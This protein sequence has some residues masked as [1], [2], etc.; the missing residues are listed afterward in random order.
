M[1]TITV[2]ARGLA[3]PEPV[4]LSKKAL[5]EIEHGEVIVYVDSD[6]AKENVAR[7]A[8]HEGCAVALKG[9]GK[10]G[11]ELRL[12]IN[13][14]A[15]A[16]KTHEHGEIK[17]REAKNKAH[18]EGIVY[19]FDADFIGTNRELGKVLVNGFLNAITSLQ[20]R[21]STIVFISNGVKLTTK[22]SYVLEALTKLKDQG[23]EML[24]CGTC[25]DYFKI[26]D[27]VKVGTISNAVEIVESLTNAQKVIRF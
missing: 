21:K 1:K 9:H 25:L 6:V 26:R 16:A 7:M 22:G 19:L 3:C 4:L 15:K 27:K 20:Q 23:Y 17:T 12:T 13:P 24:I 18:A 10:G 5:A 14:S 2:N 11:Y 8:K